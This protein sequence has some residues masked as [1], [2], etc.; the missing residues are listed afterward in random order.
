M[1]NHDDNSID[2]DPNKYHSLTLSNLGFIQNVNKIENAK[3]FDKW[4]TL[5]VYLGEIWKIWNSPSFTLTH[6]WI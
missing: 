3:G 5:A 2:L 4:N 1:F 6:V